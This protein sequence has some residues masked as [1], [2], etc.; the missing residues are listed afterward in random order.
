MKLKYL[1]LHEVFKILVVVYLDKIT[2][3]FLSFIFL[4]CY[5]FIKYPKHLLKLLVYIAYFNLVFTC[6][7]FLEHYHRVT[8]RFNLFAH[9]WFCNANVIDSE[10]I[11]FTIAGLIKI[12]SVFIV[13]HFILILTIFDLDHNDPMWH[14]LKNCIYLLV[15]LLKSC[16]KLI[17]LAFPLTFVIFPRLWKFNN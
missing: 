10:I 14:W 9:A 2:T 1:L 11:I 15:F 6:L 8:I 7:A 5:C 4:R 13:S 3:I 17:I 12:C 16:F